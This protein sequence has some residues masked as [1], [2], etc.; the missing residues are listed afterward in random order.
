VAKKSGFHAPFFPKT[1]FIDENL[2]TLT[3]TTQE[4]KKKRWSIRRFNDLPPGHSFA[5]RS[6]SR[7]RFPALNPID[8]ST[9]LEKR[10]SPQFWVANILP[11]A[12]KKLLSPSST[13]TVYGKSPSCQPE[14]GRGT[15]ISDNAAMLSY[16]SSSKGRAPGAHGG[17]LGPLPLRGD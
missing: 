16:K 17:Q 1:G 10:L 12:C 15:A 5:A 2:E 3:S 8:L 6:E 9:F 11:G 13:A 7:G 4:P 14:F